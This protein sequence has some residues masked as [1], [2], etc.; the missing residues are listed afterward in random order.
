M[1]LICR[2]QEGHTGCPDRTRARSRVVSDNVG[3]MY[4]EEK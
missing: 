4:R 3:D 2:Y 1:R